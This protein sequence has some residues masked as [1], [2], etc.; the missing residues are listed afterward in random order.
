MTLIL[1]KRLA[2]STYAI[3]GPL[4]ALANNLQTAATGGEAV[5]APPDDVVNDWEDLDG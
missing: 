5:D 2:F 4:E 1:R 3:S